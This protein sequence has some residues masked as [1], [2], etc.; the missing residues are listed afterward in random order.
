MKKSGPGSCRFYASNIMHNHLPT[1]TSGLKITL[2][3][4]NPD[5][6]KAIDYTEVVWYAHLLTLVKN[7]TEVFVSHGYFNI[8]IH[9]R[10]KNLIAKTI[11]EDRVTKK[12]HRICQRIVAS[13][14]MHFNLRLQCQNMIEAL[15]HLLY[16]LLIIRLTLNIH[17][18][19]QT[20]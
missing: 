15:S 10:L 8:L 1:C 3:N 20:D 6:S 13:S 12:P 9:S 11:I 2:L 18:S 4:L 17:S 7:T 16:F 14:F 19:Q 5:W